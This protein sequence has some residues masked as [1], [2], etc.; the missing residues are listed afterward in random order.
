[1]TSTHTMRDKD[2]DMQNATM[3]TAQADPAA[4]PLRVVRTSAPPRIAYS[5][6]LTEILLAAGYPA[7]VA[8]CRQTRL[9][10]HTQA[11]AAVLAA[12]AAPAVIRVQGRS[13]Y[14]R[15]VRNVRWALEPRRTYVSARSADPDSGVRR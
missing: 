14:E 9:R 1:M 5:P 3:P 13:L 12:A 6:G 8:A 10:E 15:A 7:V 4:H 2:H 11:L